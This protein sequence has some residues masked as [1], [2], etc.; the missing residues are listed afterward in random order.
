M[1]VNKSYLKIFFLLLISNNL[2]AADLVDVYNRAIQ[3]NDDYRIIKNDKEISLQ[4]YNQTAASI[5]PEINFQAGT[6]ETTINRYIGPGDNTDFNTDSYSLTLQQ[7]IF[8]L[9]FFDELA[10]SDA[11]IKKSEK[12]LILQKKRIALK[13]TELYFRLISHTNNLREKKEL[14]KLSEKKLSNAYKLHSNGSITKIEFLRFKSDVESSKIDRDIAQNEQENSRGDLYIFVGKKISD[15]HNVNTEI[16]IPNN[17]YKLSDVLKQ[18]TSKYEIIQM[19]NYD[20]DISQNIF[21]SNKAQ[22]F[23]TIDLIASYDYS[24]ITGGARFGANKRESSSVGLTMTLPIYQGGYQSAKVNESR[25]KLENAQIKY[26]QTLKILEKEIADKIAKYS[27]QRELVDNHRER[28]KLHN[29]KYISAKKGF[30]TGV[31]TDT[32]LQQSKIELIKAKNR[33]VDSTLNFILLD[34]NIKQYTSQIGIDEIKE[35]N[36]ILI[37]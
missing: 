35:I 6:R 33:Y 13:T 34:L 30:R 18:A 23:P 11:V 25:Y 21:E 16:K 27:I 15:I 9:A 36:S 26:E 37:W 28:Y 20:L 1:S 31:Y 12:Y 24:D 14:L 7:P 22:H 10:K 19:A 29:L 2:Y 4:Q 8:R 3:Y 17:Q 5:F 32:E